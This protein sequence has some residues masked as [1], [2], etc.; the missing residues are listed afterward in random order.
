MFCLL[1]LSERVLVVFVWFILFKPVSGFVMC[2]NQA[3]D[4]L[5]HLLKRFNE[6]FRDE[7]VRIRVHARS[8]FLEQFG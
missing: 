8:P 1:L 5:L 2:R 7:D 3:I 6:F 4:Y